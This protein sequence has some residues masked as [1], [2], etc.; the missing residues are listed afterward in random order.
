MVRTG[1]AFAEVS[2]DEGMVGCL[3]VEPE[4]EELLGL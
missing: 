1:V 2:M 4:E 3:I